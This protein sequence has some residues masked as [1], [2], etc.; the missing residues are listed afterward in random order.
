ML[1][2]TFT[3]FTCMS[4]FTKH[5]Q[6]QKIKLFDLEKFNAKRMDFTVGR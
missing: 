6:S 5:N 1:N 4:L 3:V 2:S